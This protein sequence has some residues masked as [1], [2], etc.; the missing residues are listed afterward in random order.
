MKMGQRIGFIGLSIT[1][2]ACSEPFEQDR[3]DLLNP[4]IIGIRKVDGLYQVQVWNGMGPYHDE[5]PIIS[6]LDAD[7]NEVAQ[8]LF[9]DMDDVQNVQYIDPQG[10]SHQATFQLEDS[11]ASLELQRWQIDPTAAYTLTERENLSTTELASGESSEA[12]RLG[13]EGS[14]KMRWMT[15]LGIGSFLELNRNTADFYHR[16]IVMDR[17]E[18]LLD[19]PLS[20][21]YVGLFALSINPET[22]QNQW[23]WSDIW[24]EPQPLR[25]IQNRWFPIDIA[26]DAGTQL[27]VTVHS[28]A[29][30]FGFTFTDP[31]WDTAD[32]T[33]LNCALN[34]GTFQWEWV[35][36]GLC[37]RSEIDGQRI[38]LELR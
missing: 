22:G 5:T 11:V 14:G 25:Q 13:V 38:V 16:D 9:C 32:S 34:A 2:F 23:L 33:P 30:L 28:D 35:E 7:G 21:P 18:V 12:M 3:H 4:R 24:Y 27:A 15:Q 19:E 10:N 1:L 29:S 26:D 36:M 37:L 20:D 31:S 6:W 8:G 17:D